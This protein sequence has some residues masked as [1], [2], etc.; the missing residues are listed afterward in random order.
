MARKDADRDHDPSRREFFKTFSREAIQNAGAVAGAAAEIRRTSMAAGRDLLHL[1]SDTASG[2]PTV[3]PMPIA[4][5]DSSAPQETF[6]SPYRFT[7]T[8]VVVLDQ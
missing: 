8:S 2:P 5:A 3:R 6:R 1:H 7:G 4:T